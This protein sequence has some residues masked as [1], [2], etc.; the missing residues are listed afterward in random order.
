[1]RWVLLVVGVLLIL[2]GIVWALQGAGILPG[3]VMSG[4]S[5]WLGAGIIAVLIGLGLVVAG[6]RIRPIRRL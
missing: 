4:Q 5:F 3:S 6:L 2:A 1:M